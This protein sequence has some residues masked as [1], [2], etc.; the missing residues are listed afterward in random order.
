M[1]IGIIGAG[2]MGATLAAQ[3]TRLGHQVAI[4]NSRGPRTLAGVAA[5]TGATPVHIT[6]VTSKADVV[7][8]TIPEKNI[9]ELPAG[10]LAALPGDT[11]VIDTGN[12]V[13]K[14]RDGHIDAIDAGV[15]ESQWVQSQ[16]RH[17][18]VK[19][20][21][22]IGPASLASLGKPAGAAGRAAIPVAGDD[23]A[24][25]S[26]V[27]ELA[28]QLGFDGL[29][30]G[31]LAE[32]WRQQPGTPIYTTDL[33]LDAARQALAD[34]TP[35]QTAS[36]RS[37]HPQHKKPDTTV[38]PSSRTGV[39]FVLANP[40]DPSRLNEFNDWY[41]TY[42]AAITV[43]GYLANDIH[44]E[45]PGA[46]G[47]R[48]SPRYATI[49]DI[50]AP[51]PAAAWP[52]TEH[53]PAYPTQLFSDPRATLVS[54]ALRASYALIGSQ[55]QPGPHGPLT[56]IHVILSNGGGDTERQHQETQILQTGLFYSAARF[57]IIEG[58]PE[59]AEWLQVFETDDPDPLHTYLRATSHTPPA[60]QIQT[61]LSESFRLAGARK[62][63]GA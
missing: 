46:S 49:Y 37:R 12:Y 35:E 61:Q 58:S 53:S 27:L 31:P 20:F 40:S 3:L 52:D 4:A 18:V 42:S 63:N 45:N 7:I 60:P 11:V 13:P 29:D 51:D 59:P 2:N 16:L 6:D 21:N 28:D 5:Q 38:H 44:F 9:P 56:G 41:D 43:P 47:G 19:A 22:T 25:K 1:R 55:L 57:R 34:A 14:L 33:P 32:S 8:V 23:P 30:A 54:P 17:P 10:L 15:P 50:V 26:A 39:R 36:W 62:T 24:A 48:N